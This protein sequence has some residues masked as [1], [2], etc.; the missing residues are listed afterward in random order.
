VWFNTY[1][2]IHTSRHRNLKHKWQNGHHIHLGEGVGRFL[3]DWRSSLVRARRFDGF[4]SAM[5]RLRSA[6]CL[7]RWS[8]WCSAFPRVR[9][10]SLIFLSGVEA[11]LGGAA[12]GA[13]AAALQARGGE[14]QIAEG[15]IAALWMSSWGGN[16]CGSGGGNLAAALWWDFQLAK[17][18][19]RNSRGTIDT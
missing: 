7:A 8:R 2:F 3:A 18:L 13:A 10:I 17:E 5:A 16:C 6:Q 12:A 19:Q 15:A 1:L 9:N 4:N 11:F 14:V